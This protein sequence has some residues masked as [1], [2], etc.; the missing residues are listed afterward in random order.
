MPPAG[1]EHRHRIP[2]RGLDQDVRGG[3][4]HLGGRP[5]HHA[6]EPDDA[7]V[8]GDDQVLGRERAVVAVQRGQSL[9]LVG[10][11]TRIGPESLSAS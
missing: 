2:V 5:A 7:G 9:A 10:T 6:T 8:V 1:A 11:R 3:F 4:G